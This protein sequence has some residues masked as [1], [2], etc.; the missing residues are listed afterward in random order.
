MALWDGEIK[1]CG[2][3]TDTVPPGCRERLPAVPLQVPMVQRARAWRNGTSISFQNLKGELVMQRHRLA[4]MHILFLEF[5]VLMNEQ[6]FFFL[7]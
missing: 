1:A 7:L 2:G 5:T 6:V 3:P 4:N